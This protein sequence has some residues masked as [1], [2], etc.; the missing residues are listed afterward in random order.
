MSLNQ[1]NNIGSSLSGMGDFLRGLSALNDPD[2]KKRQLVEQA[3]AA[4]PSKAEEY[5][6][7]LTDAGL[8]NLVGQKARFGTNKSQALID[9]IRKTPLTGKRLEEKNQT[10]AINL[11][12]TNNANAENKTVL[13][14]FQAY[15]AKQNGSML[16][17]QNPFDALPQSQNNG[18]DMLTNNT[19]QINGTPIA[20]TLKNKQAEDVRRKALKLPTADEEA[21]NAQRLENEKTL[22]DTAK[23][24]LQTKQAD[25]LTKSK[26]E[27]YLEKNKIS[28]YKAS[29]DPNLDPEI[30]RGLFLGEATLKDI[31]AGHEERFANAT[32]A[33]EHVMEN[34]ARDAQ[35]NKHN[36]DLVYQTANANTNASLATH[37]GVK[38]EV[39][40][41]IQDHPEVRAIYQAPGFVPKT[42]KDEIYKTAVDGLNALGG[43]I[44]PKEIAKFHAQ[45][46][47]LEKDELDKVSTDKITPSEAEQNINILAKTV[48]GG[49]GL[50]PPIIKITKNRLFPSFD[51]N[52]EGGHMSDIGVKAQIVDPGDIKLGLKNE[53]PLSAEEKNQAAQIQALIDKG[54][55]YESTVVSSRAAKFR[56]LLHPAKV[57]KK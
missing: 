29:L 3:I 48:Y 22:G 2:K 25:E 19:T 55:D 56:H 14:P 34:L 44:G 47:T 51:S 52:T 35:S 33:H 37:I 45:F 26:A 41:D 4:D 16:T 18:T 31:Q 5:N 21:A 10:D 32:V 38:P 40:E 24:N 8:Q 57:E 13:N 46:A 43:R 15:Q 1:N 36:H 17:S 30:R 23:L 39:I 12:N 27:V 7:Q 49:A 11:A 54:A 20:P 28:A 9:S 42:P 6:A 50:Q 53:A